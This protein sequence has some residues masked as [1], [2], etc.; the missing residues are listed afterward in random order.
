MSP[1][2]KLGIG[3]AAAFVLLNIFMPWLLAMAIVVGVPAAAY[4][5][6]DESQRRRLKG[7]FGRKEL[8]R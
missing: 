5:M 7:Q 8:G 6:L 4:F 1:G 3:G 2:I